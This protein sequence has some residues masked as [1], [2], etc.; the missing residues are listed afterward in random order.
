VNPLLSFDLHSLNRPLP[1]VPPTRAHAP[2]IGVFDSG[3]GGLT[4]LKAIRDKWPH[5]FYYYGLDNGFYPYGTKSESELLARTELLISTAQ[6][7]YQ[8]DLVVLACN[9]ASTLVLDHLRRRFHNLPIVVVVPAIKPA[10]MLSPRKKIGLLATKGTVTRPYIDGLIHSYAAECEVVRKGSQTLVDLAEKKLQGEEVSLAEV[11]N[12]IDLFFTSDVD[13][14]VLGC[15]HFS[16]LR[17]ELAAAA[18]RPM[19]WIDSCTAV[20]QRTSYLLKNLGFLP[21]KEEKGFVILTLTKADPKLSNP[22]NSWFPMYGI[23]E[24]QILELPLL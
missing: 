10:A 2:R 24:S 19:T 16:H 1:V 22:L 15:T 14:V 12:E 8:F 6:E 11:R 5:A 3:V 4:I 23:K 13:T 18:T 9:T 21:D 7:L 20:E 17:E